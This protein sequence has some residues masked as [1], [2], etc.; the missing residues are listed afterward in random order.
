MLDGLKM[1]LPEAK[2]LFST[3][4][5]VLGALAL[6]VAYVNASV[7][8]RYVL[9]REEIEALPDA[10]EIAAGAPVVADTGEVVNAAEASVTATD[11]AKAP[12]ANGAD[13][14]KEDKDA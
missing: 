11:E 12:L 3:M 5:A 1:L 7:K 6:W 9:S 10:A 14:G 4:A 13:E 8:Q 2:I